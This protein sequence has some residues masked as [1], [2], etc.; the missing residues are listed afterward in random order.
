MGKEFKKSEQLLRQNFWNDSKIT[1]K[2]SP[3][4]IKS[5]VQKISPNEVKNSTNIIKKHKKLPRLLE[6]VSIF[7]DIKSIC[8]CCKKIE[9]SNPS[10][11]SNDSKKLSLIQEEK[12]VHFWVLFWML[13][14]KKK[15][16]KIPISFMQ[17]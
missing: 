11:R 5:L 15:I 4:L 1:T 7:K 14:N 2:K 16:S 3:K 8:L 12:I 6:L 13:S 10:I 17:K 9:Y